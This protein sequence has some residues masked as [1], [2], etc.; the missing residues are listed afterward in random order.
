MFDITQAAVAET[1]TLELNNAADEPLLGSDG[2]RLSITLYGPGS[3]PFQK[4]ASRRQNK[5][6]ER[7][8]KKGK[9]EL[10]PEEQRADQAQFLAALT[11]SFNGFTYPPAGKAS[12]AELFKAAYADR[13]IGFVT[14]QV[15]AFVGDWGNFSPKLETS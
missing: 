7:L 2:K 15:Q 4:A 14:D 1:S 10:S 13:S 3:E 5:L 6:F 9:G 12:G 8:K 11:V